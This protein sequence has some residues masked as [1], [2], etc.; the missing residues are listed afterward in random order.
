MFVLHVDLEVK[1]G[2]GEALVQTY[3]QTFRPA[4]SRQEGF[5]SVSLLRP[6]DAQHPYRLSL[7]FDSQPLQQKWVATKLHQEVW[8]LMERHCAQYTVRRYGA[9]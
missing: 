3:T 9:I 1:P 4:I 6:Q 8:P 5:S 2:A 7:A